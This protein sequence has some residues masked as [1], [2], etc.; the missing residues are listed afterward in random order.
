MLS[1]MMPDSIRGVDTGS[2]SAWRG[3]VAAVVAHMSAGTL[4][5]LL[6]IATSPRC[7][8]GLHD[9][10]GDEGCGPHAVF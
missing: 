3:E 5:E 10:T 2:I 4:R 9:S 7:V 8:D 1:L 6:L